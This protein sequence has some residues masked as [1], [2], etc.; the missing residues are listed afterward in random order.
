MKPLGS[1]QAVV[2]AIREDAAAEVEML[3]QTTQAELDRIRAE[4][5][6]DV[7]T[8]PESA[9]RLAAAR[10]RARA[11]LAEED[12]QDAREAFAEREQ[13]IARAVAKGERQ[14][15]EAEA[16]DRRRET[17]A[18]FVREALERLP[19]GVPT[20]AAGPQARHPRLGG[21]AALAT[22]SGACEIV[23]SA[24]DAAVLDLAWS[25]RLAAL[26]GRADLR[27]IPGPVDNGCVVRTLDGRASFD[28]SY[29]ARA[30]RFESAWRAALAEVY[31]QA[32]SPSIEPAESHQR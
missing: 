6:R 7:V 15:A 8:I 21:P 1:V 17:L 29:A 25:Q 22:P 23:V 30:R 3:G 31:E 4:E 13:W 14:L 11:R 19:R 27:V 2:A 5:A 10:Q 20:A 16:S 9:S 28:N 12:W 26:T 32:A 24:A 18:V